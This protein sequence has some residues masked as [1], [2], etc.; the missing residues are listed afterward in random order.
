[1]RQTNIEAQAEYYGNIPI[2]DPKFKSSIHLEDKEDE[3]FWDTLLQQYRPGSYF[4]IY[5]SKSD[6][7]NET[8]GCTQCLKYE[9]LLSERFFICIDSD[10]R[11]LC[12]ETLSA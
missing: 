2:L 10:L 12:G 4:Y 5:H 9:G 3:L 8:S 7:G 11:F 1:M 6:S